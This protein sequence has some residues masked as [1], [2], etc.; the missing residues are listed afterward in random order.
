MTRPS[1]RT[2]D[3]QRSPRHHGGL[4]PRRP[5]PRPWRRRRDPEIADLQQGTVLL[6]RRRLSSGLG[7]ARHAA[8]RA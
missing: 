2:D 8:S 1:R 7:S 3:G 5:A 6:L 4:S